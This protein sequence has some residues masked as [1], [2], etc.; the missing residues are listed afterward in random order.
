MNKKINILE[1][2]N[3]ISFIFFI[4]GLVCVIQIVI[5]MPVVVMA[6]LTK[7]EIIEASLRFTFWYTLAIS[8]MLIGGFIWAITNTIKNKNGNRRKVF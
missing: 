8:S 7:F 1:V 4:I 5:V 6:T 2:I 3:T